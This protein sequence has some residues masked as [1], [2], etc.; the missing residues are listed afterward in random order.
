MTPAAL[1]LAALLVPPAGA[2]ARLAERFRGFDREGDG[3]VEIAAVEP[4]GARG[5]GAGDWALMLVERRL[6]GPPFA[7]AGLPDRLRR[8]LADQETEGRTALLLAVDVMRGDGRRDGAK[9]L[10]LRALLAEAAAEAERAGGR[11]RYAVLVGRFPH[12]YLVRTVNCR[13]REPLVLRRSRP[14]ERVFREPVSFLR[15][16]PEDVAHTCDLVLGD[17]DGGWERLYLEPT[18]RLP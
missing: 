13:K 9:V 3:R 11:L 15:T 17:L 16:V 10:A 4:I 7:E 5:D 2:A 18:V 1:V 14:G 12:A 8:W 6:L